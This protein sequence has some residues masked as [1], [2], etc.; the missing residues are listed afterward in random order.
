MRGFDVGINVGFW[1]YPCAVLV[2]VEEA[3]VHLGLQGPAQ[4]LYLF[5][6]WIGGLDGVIS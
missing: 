6:D 4:R 2:L 1:T 3:P 5:I